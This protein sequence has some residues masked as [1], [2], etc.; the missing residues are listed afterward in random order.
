MKFVEDGHPSAIGIESIQ[1][2]V[3][4]E[5]NKAK[6]K[7]KDHCAI[8]MIAWRALKFIRQAEATVVKISIYI[9]DLPSWC[10][11][12]PKADVCEVSLDGTYTLVGELW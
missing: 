7:S 1:D 8:K 9:K 5:D 3:M 10:K 12:S 2:N 11:G 6:L 4:D